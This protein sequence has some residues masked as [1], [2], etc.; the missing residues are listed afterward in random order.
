MG[1]QVQK[2]GH[3]GLEGK[4]LFLAH[5]ECLV[6]QKSTLCE[7]TLWPGRRGG[8]PRLFKTSVI[9]GTWTPGSPAVK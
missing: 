6:N 8:A 2:L 5:G 3:L 7:S 9:K 1:D 4:C